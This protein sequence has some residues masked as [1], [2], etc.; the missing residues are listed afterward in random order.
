VRDFGAPNLADAI[1]L[2]S[3]SKDEVVAQIKKPKHGMMPA[4]EGRLSPS[5]IRQLTLYVHALGGGEE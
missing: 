2:Y 5:T 1:W 4:W 3:A